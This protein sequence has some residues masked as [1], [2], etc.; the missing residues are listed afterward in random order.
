MHGN[1]P[2]PI[3]LNMTANVDRPVRPLAVA[4]IGR[5]AYPH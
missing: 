3:N 4:V 2:N 1:Y 5:L